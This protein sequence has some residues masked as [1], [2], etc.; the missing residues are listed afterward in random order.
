MR[1]EDKEPIGTEGMACACPSSRLERFAE[2]CLLLLLRQRPSHGYQLIDRLAQLG[3]E[4]NPPDPTVIY[5][6]LRRMEQDGFVTSKW[7]T[8]GSGPARRL[9]RLTPEGEELL[10]AW[11][12]TIRKNK[13]ALERFLKVYAADSQKAARSMGKETTRMTG[14]RP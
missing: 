14:S 5:R 1:V 11:A 8:E 6:T 10:H 4:E 13:T 12:V 7:V 2:A 3:L 9:Y